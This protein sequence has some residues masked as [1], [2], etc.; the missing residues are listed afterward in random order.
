[1]ALRHRLTQQ[2]GPG[3]GPYTDKDD[4]DSG[5]HYQAWNA[6]QPVAVQRNQRYDRT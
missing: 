1:M 2:A 4:G 3:A 6:K 5:E